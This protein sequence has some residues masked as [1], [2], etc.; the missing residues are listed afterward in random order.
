M[1]TETIHSI[2]TA[3]RNVFRNWRTLLLIAAVYACLLAALY[4]FMI[5]REASLFQVILTFA[6]ALLAP[7]LFFLLQALIA[8]GNTDQVSVGE[9]MRRSL[10]SFWKLILV[11]LPLIALAVLAVYLLNKAQ[12]RFG[13]NVAEAA[14]DLPRRAVTMAGAREA[15]KPIDWRAALLSTL[16]Y[17]TFGLILPLAAIHVWLATAR[18]GLGSA[19][20]KIRSLL[21]RAF[22]PQSVF[23]YVAGFIT[24]AVI[25]YLLLF[26]TVSTKHAWLEITLLV[27]RLAVVFAL[28]LL[29]WVITV[30]AL[31]LFA[32]SA[33]NDT[34]NEAT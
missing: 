24:F 21:A 34:A 27:A 17:L 7:L 31:A 3:S 22:A 4:L 32:T 10:T 12:A 5:I 30:K 13:A 20:K 23:I 25:P 9:L 16:R 28:T 15:G 33:P 19:I 1:L 26:K 6:L 8:S 18:E 29:G 14:A 2:A 11:T